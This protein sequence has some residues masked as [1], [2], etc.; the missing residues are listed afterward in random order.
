MEAVPA[1]SYEF[2]AEGSAWAMESKTTSDLADDFVCFFD[3]TQNKKKYNTQY[4][5]VGV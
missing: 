5:C 1:S 2:M 4:Y 3:N